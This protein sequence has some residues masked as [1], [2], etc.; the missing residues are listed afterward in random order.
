MT[1]EDKVDWKSHSISSRESVRQSWLCLVFKRCLNMDSKNFGRPHSARDVQNLTRGIIL[2]SGS[3]GLIGTQLGAFLETDG[4]TSID[5]CNHQQLHTDQLEQDVR[6]NDK[7]GEILEGSL[8]GFD[9]VIHLAGA[10]IG[11]KRWS[12]KRKNLIAQSR[13]VPTENLSKALAALDAPPSLFMCA[14]TATPT[15]RGSNWM[16][17]VLEMAS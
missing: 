12:K 3:T 10:G 5:S 8:E 9:V 17:Q 16:N 11:D 4:T 6:W 15:L 7:T 2:I 1:I 13:A 14:S